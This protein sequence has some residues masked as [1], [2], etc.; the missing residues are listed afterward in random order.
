MLWEYVIY[1]L[2]K[3]PTLEIVSGNKDPRTVVQFKHF[4]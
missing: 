3:Q 1:L 2:L 4:L